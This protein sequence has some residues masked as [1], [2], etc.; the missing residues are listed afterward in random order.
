MTAHAPVP[1]QQLA[2]QIQNIVINN[3][4]TTIAIIFFVINLNDIINPK[5]DTA[6]ITACWIKKITIVIKLQ[7]PISFIFVVCCKRTHKQ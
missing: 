3:Y 7:F 2:Q 6:I 1:Q 4:D 5:L